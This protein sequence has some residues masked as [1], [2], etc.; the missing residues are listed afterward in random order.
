MAHAT[1]QTITA[2][3]S[4][5]RRNASTLTSTSHRAKRGEVRGIH[6]LRVA[7][8][9]LREA[10]PASAELAENEHLDSD[11]LARELRRV[12]R[13][14]GPVRE[15]DVARRVLADVADRE[16][17]PEAVVARIDAYCQRLRDRALVDAAAA[18]DSFDAREVRKGLEALSQLIE[19]SE[20]TGKGDELERPARESS[21]DTRRREAA[22]ILSRRIEE[23]GTL[24]APTA[25]HE[26]R[27]AAKK[28]RYVVELAGEPSPGAL[29]RLRALQSG[30]GRM[31]DAQVLQHRIQEL[32]A[33]SRDRG[34]V[35][36]MTSMERT[37]ETTCREWHAKLLKTLPGIRALADAITAEVPANVRPRNLGRPVRMTGAKPA[38]SE[39]SRRR[40]RI[41]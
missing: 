27:I 7:T 26:I 36:T 21:L 3:V 33:T 14:L 29:R 35:A 2:L 24:Y 13:G 8:R 31:H 34:L 41:A 5:L 20:K 32:A 19:K 15:L 10:L 23:A 38:A 25:L 22:R 37:L 17:W 16:A 28:L 12:T 9:R 4:S 39:A 6:R 18:I 40:P 1:T 30:L 11:E